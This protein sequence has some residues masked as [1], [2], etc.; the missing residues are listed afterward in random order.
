VASSGNHRIYCKSS[1][2]I[3][4]FQCSIHYP[5]LALFLRTQIIINVLRIKNI[6]KKLRG[7]R[8]RYGICLKKI[9]TDANIKMPIRLAIQ[10]IFFSFQLPVTYLAVYMSNT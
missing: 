2:Y 10:M 7:K 6:Y 9:V 1:Q 5:I 8:H 3:L 4:P